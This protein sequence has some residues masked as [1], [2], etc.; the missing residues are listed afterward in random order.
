[1]S[2]QFENRAFFGIKIAWK[3][4]KYLIA[5]NNSCFYEHYSTIIDIILSILH[6]KNN[7]YINLSLIYYLNLLR[8]NIFIIFRTK[9]VDI[10]KFY[11]ILSME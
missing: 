1:M 7:I 4:L 9:R 10:S 2:M 5:P 3:A 8:K 6:F 11:I